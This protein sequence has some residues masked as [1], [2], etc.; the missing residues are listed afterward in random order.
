[1]KRIFTSFNFIAAAC[2]LLCGCAFTDYGTRINGERRE[3]ESLEGKYQDLEA[4]YVIVLNSL[5]KNLGDSKLE[6]ERDKVR[7]KMHALNARIQEKRREF[8]MSLEEWEKKIVQDNLQKA[9][10]DKEVIDNA[11][12][13]EG[14][15]NTSQ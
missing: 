14:E 3:L 9:L 7:D 1:M 10:I 5:E 2:A 4:R 6:N 12:K 8:D 13:V 11:N 15:W